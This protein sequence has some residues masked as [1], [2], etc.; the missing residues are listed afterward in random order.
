MEEPAAPVIED[1]PPSYSESDI[2]SIIIQQVPR[3]NPILMPAFASQN[4]LL[5]YPFSYKSGSHCMLVDSGAD[6]T[7]VAEHF[8]NRYHLPTFKSK[9]KAITL[10]DKSQI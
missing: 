3:D 4:K 5:I 9:V 8:V 1:D 6:K 10:A 7:I 2:D